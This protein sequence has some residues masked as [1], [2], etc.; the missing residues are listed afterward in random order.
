METSLDSR[1]G[2]VG[3]GPASHCFH[4]GTPV[5][6]V[7]GSSLH[8]DFATEGAR[9][10]SALAEFNFIHHFPEGSTMVGPMFPK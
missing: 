6:D 3:P 8:L 1:N 4:A 2:V 10:P 5:P 9:G 7:K